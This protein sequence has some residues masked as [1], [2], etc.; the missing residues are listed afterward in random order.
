M[1]RGWLGKNVLVAEP[2]P[3]IV[4]RGAESLLYVVLVAAVYG[5]KGVEVGDESGMRAN[6]AGEENEEREKRSE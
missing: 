4:G 3:A 5:L 6:G 2:E 1:L